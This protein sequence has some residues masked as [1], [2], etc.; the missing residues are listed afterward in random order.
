MIAAMK[1]VRAALAL[2]LSTFVP[3]QIFGSPHDSQIL[4]GVVTNEFGQALAGVHMAIL[5]SDSSEIRGAVSDKSGGF[6]FE[7]L[8]SGALAIVADAPGFTRSRAE[9]T[10]G[11]GVGGVRVSFHLLPPGA[12]C[13]LQQCVTVSYLRPAES[14]RVTPPPAPPTPKTAL[15]SST[16]LATTL[17]SPAD[18]TIQTT[19]AAPAPPR[20]GFNFA[21]SSQSA[22]NIF[23]DGGGMDPYD[24]R[25]SLNATDA[26]T[27]TTFIDN[28]CSSGNC[29]GTDFYQSI[30][31][32]YFS[33][34]QA[35]VYHFNNTTSAW[36]LINSG[37]VTSYT[38]NSASTNPLDHT[39]TLNNSGTPSQPGDAIWL[40][41]DDVP[42]IPN[43]SLLDPRL[44]KYGRYDTLWTYETG[45]ALNNLS[46]QFVS[47]TNLQPYTYAADGPPGDNAEIPGAASP[48]SL[49]ITDTKQEFAGINQYF[50]GTGPG[51]TESLQPG[52]TYQISLWL[53]QS[54]IANGSVS[55][56]I[57]GAQTYAS[58]TFTG[59]TGTWQLFTYQFAGFLAPPTTEPAPQIH[60]D[61]QAPGTLWIDQVEISDSGFPVLT[62]DPRVIAAWQA[63]APSTMRIWTNFTNSGGG[64]SYWGLDSWLADDSEDHVDPGIGNI[65]EIHT[66]HA[67][68]PSSLAIAK[69]VGAEP[70]LICNMSL[71]E[72]EWGHLIDYL[73]APAGV[74]YAS[75]RPAS[76]PGPYTTD[77]NHIYLEFG[78]EEW[79]TQ[80]TAVNGHYGAWVHYM[81]SQAI[82]GKAY[83]DPSKVKFIVNGFT[84]V[85]GIGSAAIAAAPEAS[86]VDIFTY[87]SGDTT[88]TG[89]P[90][91][92]SD[93]FSLI[94]NDASYGASLQSLINA[95]VAQ[96]KQDAA[97]GHVYNLAV[98]EGGPGADTPVHQGD[99]SLAAAVGNLDTFLYSSLVGIQ[100]QNFFLFNFGS[101]PYS[102]HSYL[103]DGLLPHPSW[104]A[105]Q[106]R[107]QYANGDMVNI[108]T[109][110]VPVTSDANAFPLISSYAFH[111]INSSGVNQA[112]VFVLSRDLNNATPVTLRLPGVPTT[113]ATLYTLTGDPRQ[114]NDTQ[115]NIP[116]TK[117]ALTTVAQNYQF[118]MPPGSVYLFQF[119][120]SSFGTTTSAATFIGL[121][122]TSQGTWTGKYGADGDLIAKDSANPPAYSTV[123]L[124]GDLLYTWASPTTD[125]RALQ[126]AR[127]SFARIASTYYSSSSFTINVNLTDGNAHRVALY[128]LDWD[129]DARSE[130][131]SI[132]DAASKAVLDTE[133]F[134]GFKNGEYAVWNLQGDVIIQ[135]TRNKGANAVVAG[136]FFDPLPSASASATYS[137]LDSIT[138][139]TWTGVYGS[140]GEIIANDLADSPIVAAGFTGGALY[141]WAYPTSTDQSD[142]RALQ[143]TSG[144]STR[145]A[146]TY[147]SKTA[148]NIDVNVTDG[149]THKVSLYLLDWDSTVRTETISI[150]DTA[151]GAV[152][153]TEKFSKFHNGEYAIWNIQ[154]N[155]TIEVTKTGGAN[156]VVSAIFF[157]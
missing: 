144:S 41:E 17:N 67:H 21:A 157:D 104:E 143:I 90:Y 66:T 92:Q 54:G 29:P 64:Y 22:N 133:T 13:K 81:L 128:L 97:N 113:G 135:I 87:N 34:A 31:T 72:A 57:S 9:V 61:F 106:M 138:Q 89:D 119:P 52:H 2:F 122:Q 130:T 140:N 141:D 53:K 148:F 111:E 49:K 137:G 142:S 123:S 110:S 155:V 120:L 38:A 71:S 136:I 149:K 20:F 26:G 99:T 28:D 16:P 76:H 59:V 47:S 77:F 23:S 125:V 37:T 103:Y 84:L 10:L 18:F 73:T 68:L 115:L 94:R 139:G 1:F 25:F 32:G 50:L 33:G 39:I 105:L 8:P 24:A 108:K 114:N 48:L 153:D 11:H 62:I 154:G 60:I 150:L 58:T 100:Q 109:N 35:R 43:Y 65:Y 30:A 3:A 40:T 15:V 51:S 145:V 93:L 74:G 131:I 86:I 112:D 107:N 146:N 4:T 69:S 7:G 19:I 96:Q 124:T 126:T 27:A 129:S 134:S 45:P 14:L 116:I 46:S 121:D 80:E 75:L 44:Q 78:N 70:W 6:L 147:F 36:Q 95:Q 117:T 152:L 85:P 63:Y 79:G 132:L 102:S 83:F 91:Y 12:S 118:T 101:G 56:S 156:A 127:A 88:L 98:Y 42:A 82:A 55:F 151:N 5:D